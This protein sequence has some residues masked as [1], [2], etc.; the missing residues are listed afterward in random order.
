MP[1]VKVT[2]TF[3]GSPKELEEYGGQVP[4]HLKKIEDKM[5]KE[6]KASFRGVI[7]QGTEM[8]VS[9]KRAEELTKLGVV[10]EAK[11]E[12]AKADLAKA[13]SKA[14]PKKTETKAS[15]KKGK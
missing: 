4:E 7:T 10:G 6:E 11:A 14:A 8:E 12:K 3:I 5:T 13:E 2:S 15:T 1:K 9:D